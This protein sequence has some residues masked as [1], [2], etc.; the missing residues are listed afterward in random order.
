MPTPRK[1]ED[2]ASFRARTNARDRAKRALLLKGTSTLYKGDIEV[3]RWDKTKLAGRPPEEAFRL[4]D[5][6]IVSKVS[7]LYDQLGDVTQQWV[8]ERPEAAAQRELW[9]E[10]AK[11]L[12]QTLPRV[13]PLPAPD[14]PL[15]SEIMACYP[16]GDHHVGMLSWAQE[17]GA[18]Y[19]VKTAEE[20]LVGAIKHLVRLAPACERAA[21][22]FLGDFVHFDGH[23]PLTPTGRNPL[24]A[25]GRYQNVVRAAIRLMRRAVEIAAERHGN[26]HVIVEIGNHDLAS[27]VFLMEALA[28]IYEDNPR[29]TIDTNPAHFHYFTFGA[30]L[31]GTNHG[32]GPKPEVLPLIMAT[33]RPEEWGASFHR[34]WW[35]GHVHHQHAREYPGC[36]VE[37]FAVLPPNDAYAHNKGYRSRRA[38]RSIV[39]H[40]E[41]GEVSRA[42]VTPEMLIGN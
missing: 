37:S 11:E 38:M 9:L 1:G 18:N 34:Y 24:D 26:V 41:Y 27:A 23:V 42:I 15:K 14:G 22:V 33:D 4:A 6:K 12:A 16:V 10:W 19:D 21:V 13:D 28:Q 7:T 40:A 17:T 2:F 32:H 29:I 8:T 35:T 3:A 20:L 25:D 31:V 39:L 36:S 5:P 30:N